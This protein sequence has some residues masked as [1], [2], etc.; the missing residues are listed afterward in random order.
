MGR[1]PRLAS[2]A[3]SEL[4]RAPSSAR[5]RRSAP[6]TDKLAVGPLDELALG[7]STPD[8]DNAGPDRSRRQDLDCG[9]ALRV[10]V[11]LLLLRTVEIKLGP[12][13]QSHRGDYLGWHPASATCTW[14]WSSDSSG[15][16]NNDLPERRLSQ[17][18]GCEK[19]QGF[20]YEPPDSSRSGFSIAALEWVFS[21]QAVRDGFPEARR[22]GFRSPDQVRCL[23]LH[24]HRKPPGGPSGPNG[25]EAR[26][27]SQG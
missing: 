3:A 16:I 27:H 6:T 11:L 2:G 22:R 19:P 24:C 1:Q 18:T 5:V 20:P 21:M 4:S 8:Q 23:F 13:G 10:L 12:V 25:I 17:T 14:P 7:T 15:A 26:L 9:F